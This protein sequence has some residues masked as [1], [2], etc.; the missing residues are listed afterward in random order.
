MCVNSHSQC[1]LGSSEAVSNRIE[2]MIDAHGLLPANT[3]H[4]L[5]Q[6]VNAAGSVLGRLRDRSALRSS[7]RSLAKPA[8][9]ISCPLGRYFVLDRCA[10][11]WCLLFF[12][13]LFFRVLGCTREWCSNENLLSVFFDC[14]F[15]PVLM[16]R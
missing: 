2:K 6:A 15:M 12:S 5:L 11:L 16:I 14:R 10:G 8:E 13:W 9:P 1:T 3:E 4:C 7:S